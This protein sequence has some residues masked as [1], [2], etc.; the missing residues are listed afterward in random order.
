[1]SRSYKCCITIID[2][3]EGI[4]PTKGNRSKECMI[5]HYWFFNLEFK[6]QDSV[7]NGYHDLTI[8]CLNISHIAITTVKDVVYCCI[9]HDI[10]KSETINLLKKSVFED[11][12]YI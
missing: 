12:G 4:D 6:F 3:S 9:I 5:C 1:M 11:C 8:L 7:C 10:S 2:K